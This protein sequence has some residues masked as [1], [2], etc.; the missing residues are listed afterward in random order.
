MIK[1]EIKKEIKLFCGIN[2]YPLIE[3]FFNKYQESQN[4]NIFVNS[5]TIEI[6]KDKFKNKKYFGKNC[7]FDGSDYELEKKIKTTIEN[8]II[9]LE[10][11]L[12]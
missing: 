10:K 7:G 11:Y 9:Y 12:N 3:I 6:I 4:F 5:Q 2:Y 8:L 1:N